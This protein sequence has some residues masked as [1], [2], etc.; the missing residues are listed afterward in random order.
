MKL[1]KEDIFQINEFISKK[2]FASIR[3]YFK[4]G[5]VSYVD[6]L[7]LLEK[8][9]YL[10]DTLAEEEY[11]EVVVKKQQG[12]IQHIERSVKKKFL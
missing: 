2:N 5:R 7:E 8:T 1:H 10:P 12:Q 3:L 9:T 11:Q 4:G 6:G